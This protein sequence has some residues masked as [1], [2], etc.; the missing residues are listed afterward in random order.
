M[1]VYLDNCCYNRPY[2]GYSDA[3]STAE[4][5]AIIAIIAICE[6][7]GYKIFGSP[8]VATEIDGIKSRKPLKW[9]QVRGFYERTATEYITPSSVIETRARGFVAAGLGVYDAYHLAYSEAALVDVLLTTDDRF[10]TTC[11]REKLSVVN[12][13]SPITFLPEV[14]E[15]VQ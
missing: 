15:W 8:A 1:K 12:V 7:T 11:A 13:M 5:A 14:E 6:L 3:R 4:V 2:D 10:I 9:H